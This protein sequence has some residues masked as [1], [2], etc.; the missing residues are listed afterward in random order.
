[1]SLDSDYDRDLFI[2][3]LVAV[4]LVTITVGSIAVSMYSECFIKLA[5][6][7]PCE[8]YSYRL[9]RECDDYTRQKFLKSLDDYN[10]GETK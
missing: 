8:T 3:R 7:H 9:Q 10:K 6:R 1:M 5:P 2:I 4:I